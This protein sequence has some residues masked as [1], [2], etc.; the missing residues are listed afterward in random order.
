LE[1]AASY[2][3]GAQHA[4]FKLGD[5]ALP[6]EQEPIVR[7]ARVINPVEIDHARAD[8][9]AELQQMMPVAA[10]AGKPRS[11][12]A[13][14]GANVSGAKPRDEPIEARPRHRPARKAPKVVVNDLDVPEAVAARLVDQIILTPLAFEIGQN[15]GLRR[16]PDVHDSFP[17]QDRRRKEIIAGHRRLPALRRHL[18]P[19]SESWPG[20]RHYLG[21]HQLT[22]RAD[23]RVHSARADTERTEGLSIFV[24]SHSRPIR[25]GKGYCAEGL[26]GV[27]LA[28]TRCDWPW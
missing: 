21:D 26:G 27:Q 3:S 23:V 2:H 9:T 25:V 12:E 11:I 19:A 13:Q 15:L 1:R 4:E 22:D 5:A 7:A 28:S 20:A 24:R 8:K 6:A 16:L 17:L 14:H 18:L 10:V